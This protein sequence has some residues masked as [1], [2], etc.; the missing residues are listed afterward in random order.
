[1]V[2]GNAGIV[3]PRKEYKIMAEEIYKLI[4]SSVDRKRIGETARRRVLENYNWD[5]N[6]KKME[7]IYKL[8]IDK[9]D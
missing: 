3:V 1:M 4:L 7:D 6:V 8:L 9:V 2:D 5:E